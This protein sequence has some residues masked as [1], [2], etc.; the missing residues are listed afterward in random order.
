[1]R[2]VT[3]T[4]CG[5]CSYAHEET[6]ALDRLGREGLFL[7][8][9]D[10]GAGK[11]T[12]FDA[13]TYALYGVSSG[14]IRDAAML[15]CRFFPAHEKPFVRLV[16]RHNGHTYTVERTLSYHPPRRKNPVPP[17]AQDRKSVV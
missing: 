4:L 10:T 15:R 17:E 11:T 5:F 12:I 13:I 3:L 2:P 1:M 8:S 14:K 9:G 7:I 6:L 16:F